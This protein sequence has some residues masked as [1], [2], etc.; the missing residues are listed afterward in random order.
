VTRAEYAALCE[1]LGTTAVDEE[2]AILSAGREFLPPVAI[3]VL[4]H[5]DR[6]PSEDYWTFLAEQ[7]SQAQEEHDRE[8]AAGHEWHEVQ[9]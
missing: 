5:R 6:E 8:V 9:S 1:S 3:D 2:N 7:T 4:D